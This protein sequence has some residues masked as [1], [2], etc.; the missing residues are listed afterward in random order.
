MAVL[1]VPYFL[2]SAPLPLL[3][4]VGGYQGKEGQR[5]C[6]GPC[7]RFLFFFKNRVEGV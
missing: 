6:S 7:V 1:H 5:Y 2:N 4:A 3:K